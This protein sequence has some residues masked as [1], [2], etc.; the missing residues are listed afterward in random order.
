[1]RRLSFVLIAWLFTVYIPKLDAAPRLSAHAYEPFELGGQTLTFLNPE[2]MHT[3]EMTWLKMQIKWQGS[4]ADAQNV[5]NHARAHGFKV[6]LSII[7]VQ[8]ELAANPTLYYQNFAAFLGQVAL[9]NPDAIEVWN[10][11]NIDQEWPAGLISGTAYAQMLSQAYPAIKNANPNVM[12]IS[13][14]PAPTGYFGGGC[15]FN[16]CDDLPFIQQMK[17]AGADAYFDCTGMHYNEG[18]VSPKQS[19]GDP[20]GNPNHYTRYYSTMVSTYRS[21]FPN[22][23]LC[24]TELGYLTPE[25]LG[26]LPPGVEWAANTSVQEQ[27]QWLAEAATLSRESGLVRLMVVWNVNATFIPSNYM[28]GWAIVRQNNQCAACLTLRDAM[29]AI[30]PSLN[31]HTVNTVPL[32]WS[33]VTG[34]IGYQV[35]VDNAPTFPAPLEH[36]QFVNAP[37]TQITTPALANGRHFWRVRAQFGPTIWGAWSAVDSFTIAA[38]P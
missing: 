2:E 38:P 24:I 22:K 13:G 3:A 27:A 18:V 15:A 7:G 28:A 16:G 26:T 4:T 32:S 17:A 19:S 12:V 37:I 36:Q 35:E 11:P 34:A 21:V 25:G 33:W 20:R 1:M 9:L 5:I 8:S 14:A 30:P 29:R 10:E 23:P 6:L 31:Y